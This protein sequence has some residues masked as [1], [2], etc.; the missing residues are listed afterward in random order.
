MQKTYFF[1][2]K[3]EIIK[4]EYTGWYIE[5]VDDSQG[6][7]GGYYIVITNPAPN[8]SK[9]YDSWLEEEE[10]VPAYINEMGWEINWLTS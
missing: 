5:L 4:G 6:E 3:G 8:I 2:R 9:T 1:G 7:T 10:D